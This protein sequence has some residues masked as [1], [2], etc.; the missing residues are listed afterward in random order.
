[1]WIFILIIVL[2][3]IIGLA[4][5]GDKNKTILDIEVPVPGKCQ[6]IFML[7]FIKDTDAYKLEL[8]FAEYKRQNFYLKKLYLDAL[9]Y[10]IANGGLTYRTIVN[11][12]GEETYEVYDLI[13]Y[14][15]KERNEARK[16]FN[17]SSDF[18]I[19]GVHIPSRKYKIRKHCNV[20]DIIFLKAEPKNKFDSNAIKVECYSGLIGYIKIT[21]TAEV[22][23]I[24]KNEY[25]AFISL[26]SDDDN[27]LSLDITIEF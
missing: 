23:E 24:I 3:V 4:S 18:E 14:F 21:D 27:Y 11:E 19:T 7:N 25:Y 12:G 16:N 10:K 1:M 8:V 6:D 17:N 9:N 26:I 15:Q 22:H 2:L 13:G 20:D 5:A